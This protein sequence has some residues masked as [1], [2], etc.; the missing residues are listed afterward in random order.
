[1]KISTRVKIFWNRLW[2]RRDEF[3]KSL[4]LDFDIIK[5][6]T[7]EE[8]QAYHLDLA[9]RRQIAHQRDLERDK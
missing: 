1:M 2:I 3:H 7:T 4:D 5:D 6:M 8:R 9:K